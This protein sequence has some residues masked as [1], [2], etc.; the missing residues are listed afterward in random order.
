MSLAPMLSGMAGGALD[1]VGIVVVSF[2]VLLHTAVATLLV[3][4]LPELWRQWN[5]A[6]EEAIAPVM[7]SEALPTVSVVVTGRAS[8]LWTA[9]TVRSLLALRYPRHEVVLVHDGTESGFL[10][11]LIEHFDL[12]QVPPAILVNV[13]TGPARGYYRSRRHGKLFVIDK[14]HAGHADDLNAA[15]NASRFPYVLTMDVNTRL[16][17]DALTRL[18]RPF[19][20]AEPIASVAATTRV[21][22][23]VHPPAAQDVVTEVPFGWLGGMQAIEQL[24]D[25]VFARLGW[26]RFGGQLPDRGGVLL[27]RREQLLELDGYRTGVADPERDLVRRLRARVRGRLTTAVPALPDAVAWTLAPERLSTIARERSAVHRRR[28]EELLAWRGA[29][30]DAAAG[31]SGKRAAVVLAAFVVAPAMELLGYVLLALALLRGGA[32]QPFVALF[33]LAVP[34][35]ALLLSLWAVAFERAGA[36]TLRSWREVMRLCVFAVAEQLGY[37]QRIMWARLGA[38]VD[39]LLRRPRE[40][41]GRIAPSPVPADVRGTADGVRAR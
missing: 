12:Y 23:A 10:R 37:R 30:H 1:A 34:G 35:Y 24:R 39:A 17:P 3:S 27:H 13:P 16:E 36:G 21:G 2:F 28:I 32:S 11:M 5:L 29:T 4:A 6:E 18:M 7:G 20:L 15:L 9:A 14:P 26:N 33:L 25:G 22:R 8:R 31:T 40:D 41:R 19:L 38:A